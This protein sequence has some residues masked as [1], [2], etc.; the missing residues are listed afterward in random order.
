MCSNI[1]NGRISRKKYMIDLNYEFICRWNSNIYDCRCNCRKERFG[2]WNITGNWTRFD[3]ESLDIW[4]SIAAAGPI[5]VLAIII[6]IQYV[7]E[8]NASYK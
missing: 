8:D 3:S 1:W 6:G 5:D 7:P 4:S 2:S